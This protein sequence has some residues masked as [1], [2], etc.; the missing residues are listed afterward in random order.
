MPTLTRYL[1]LEL[2]KAFVVVLTVLTLLV[3]FFGVM[4]ELWPKDV[5]AAQIVKIIPFM[6][7]ESMRNAA[8]GAILYAMC[9]VFG[10]MAS[11]NELLAAKSLGISPMV[12]VRPAL[13]LATLT[14]FACIWLYDVGSSWGV[15][16]VR[17]VVIES[18]EAIAY[19]TLTSQR[20]YSSPHLSINVKRVDGRRLLRP[21]LSYHP[22]NEEQ[23]ITITAEEGYLRSNLREKTLTIVFSNGSVYAADETRLVFPETFEQVVPLSLASR[24]FSEQDWQGETLAYLGKQIEQRQRR[25]A[26]LE[27]AVL[28]AEKQRAESLPRLRMDLETE[29]EKHTYF[30]AVY[31]RR[32]AYGFFC[33]SFAM[34]GI[35]VS[36]FL[37]SGEALKAFLVCFLPI[38][39]VNQPLHNFSIKLAQAGDAPA[40][41]PWF[42]NFVLMG[43]GVWMLRKSIRH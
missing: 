31:H 20:S 21:T 2:L 30:R 24:D 41:F 36:I 39:T 25:V 29:R 17:R 15:A 23:A 4:T 13:C 40:W 10:K 32:W 34:I 7:P 35:P 19:S 26:Q 1:L 5:G 27:Q 18:V 37:R 33:L 6:L 8:Q 14:S 43:V 38:I 28:T 42:G 3:L 12:F 11:N 16:G 22:P 9:A